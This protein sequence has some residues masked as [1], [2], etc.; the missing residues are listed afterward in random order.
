MKPLDEF[1][2]RFLDKNFFQAR[3]KQYDIPR[4]CTYLPSQCSLIDLAF[5]VAC[6]CIY[7]I[8]LQRKPIFCHLMIEEL[9][10]RIMFLLVHKSRIHWWCFKFISLSFLVS[11]KLNPFFFSIHSVRSFVSDVNNPS[12]T[13]AVG[14]N[15]SLHNSSSSLFS[16]LFFFFFSP[17]P[18]LDTRLFIQKKKRELRPAHR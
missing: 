17:L 6:Y 10:E 14:S 4:N 2:L 18:K 3:L 12:C 7:I 1:F 13:A 15:L 5:P 11:E 9:T 8:A 16:L